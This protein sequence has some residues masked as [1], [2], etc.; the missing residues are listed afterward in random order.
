MADLS[1]QGPQGSG[2]G[3]FMRELVDRGLF[4]NRAYN[5]RYG[6]S[7]DPQGVRQ[8]L[9][10][11]GAGALVP[12]GST[13]AGLAINMYNRAGMNNTRR[14]A[15][16]P[17]LSKPTSGMFTPN[18]APATGTLGSGYSSFGSGLAGMASG[19][20]PQGQ[21]PMPIQQV[22]LTPQGNF[23][24]TNPGITTQG[25]NLNAFSGAPMSG[26]AGSYT[27]FGASRIEGQAAQDMWAGMQ[28]GIYGNRQSNNYAQ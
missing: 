5:Y 11:T 14:N 24:T 20:L 13:L 19:G 23:Q 8:G 22:Q 16:N 6:G 1:K 10:Q 3:R 26:F 9:L 12:G 28:Q 21:Q 4:A 17:N 15:P 18:R 2:F 27:P 7:Y 25:M